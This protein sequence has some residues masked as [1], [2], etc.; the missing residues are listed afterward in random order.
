MFNVVDT[1]YTYRSGQCVLQN[2]IWTNV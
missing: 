1:S 2:I